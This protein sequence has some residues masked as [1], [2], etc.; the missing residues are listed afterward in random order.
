MEK[1]LDQSKIVLGVSPDPENFSIDVY[2]E[3]DVNAYQLRIGTFLLTGCKGYPEARQASGPSFKFL[4][5]FKDTRVRGQ[6]L[7]EQNEDSDD[8]LALQGA[9]SGS[10]YQTLFGRTF[11]TTPAAFRVSYPFQASEIDRL[12][13]LLLYGS[14]NPTG[15]DLTNLVFG[16]FMPFFVEDNRHG[17]V[18]TPGFYGPI[19]PTTGTRSTIK[20]FSNI[21]QLFMDVLALVFKYLALLAA[22]PWTSSPSTGGRASASWCAT[23]TIR[24]PAGCASTFSRAAC[25]PCWHVPRSS[26]P[27]ASASRT[28]SPGMRRIPSSCRPIRVKRWSS[29]AAVPMPTSTGNSPSTRRG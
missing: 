4:P 13:A 5:K 3:W 8:Q 11:G 1:S 28:P 19:D 29:T 25:R 9:F 26:R 22:A 6:R 16:T 23:S 7:V 2:F 17:Y 10:D 20:T 27:A 18:L 12:L 24:W 21:R 15:R 14:G